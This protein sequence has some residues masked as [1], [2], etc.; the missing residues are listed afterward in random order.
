MSYFIFVTHHLLH[1]HTFRLPWVIPN[2]QIWAGRWF[3]LILAELNYGADIPVFLAV[4]GI[5]MGMISG[6]LALRSWRFVLQPVQQAIVV[7]GIVAF[8]MTLSFFYFSY[9]TPLFFSGWLFA[10][11]AGY[12]AS[13]L[14]VSRLVFASVMVMLTL[15]SYQTAL[16]VFVTLVVTAMI[17]DLLSDADD[18]QQDRLKRAALRG[19]TGLFATL[20]GLVLYWVSLRVPNINTPGNT[21]LT[22]L[23]DLPGRFIDVAGHAYAHLWVSQPDLLEPT[24]IVLL[25]IT[26]SAVLTTSWRLRKSPILLVASLALWAFAIVATKSIFILVSPN[27][28][29]YDYRY[30]TSMGFF[31]AFSFFVLMRFW[32]RWSTAATIIS[33]LIIV[34]FMQADLVR[35]EVLLRGQQHDLAIANRILV[36][37][38]TLPGLDTSK[39]YDLVRI[40]RY[41]SYRNNL[42]RSKGHDF[43]KTGDGHMDW[44][45]ISASWVDEE[46]FRLL[47]SSI[48]FKHQLTDSQFNSKVQSAR[49]NLL[50]NRQPWPAQDSVFIEGE[51]IY[52]YMR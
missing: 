31:H 4:L 29:I 44:G 3:N 30:N 7:S 26:V 23:V 25:G 27:G 52:I 19:A 47:G 11:F 16:S 45:E 33:A 15:A 21:T 39:V 36:R 24:K 34:R 17:T 1:N 35:Q 28:S 14:S 5:I 32:G 41:S 38:E 43:D 42:M 12:A 13:H 37:M 46:V 18:T 40:G 22:S 6:L 50:N 20:G 48:R 8:P 10:A 9:Q 51:T 2:D 49:D